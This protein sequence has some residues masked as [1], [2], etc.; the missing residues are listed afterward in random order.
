MDSLTRPKAGDRILAEWA[1]GIV[2]HLR[3]SRLVSS[4]DFKVQVTSRGTVVNAVDEPRASRPLSFAMG[5]E[6][7]RVYMGR[8]VSDDGEMV[9][10]RLLP[11]GD[12]QTQGGET[13][14]VQKE[15]L[16]TA[17][18]GDTV[19]CLLQPDGSIAGGELLDG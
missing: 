1:R 3:K 13:V 12:V 11:M 17:R 19:T 16:G 2:E 8:I 14:K 5:K 7:G 6:A 15:L 18:V 4:R 10:V 9:E